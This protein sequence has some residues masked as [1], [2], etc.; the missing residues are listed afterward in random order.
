MGFGAGH[1]Q[2]MN[3]RMRQNRAQRPSKRGKFKDDNRKTI[4]SKEAKSH[5]LSFKTLPKK[6]MYKLKLKIRNR[7]KA[8]QKRDR[9]ILWVLFI[10]GLVLLIRCIKF[11]I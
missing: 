10:I 6:E 1:I 5:H 9:I 3:N 4:Y 2:D 7:A 11:L 8:E